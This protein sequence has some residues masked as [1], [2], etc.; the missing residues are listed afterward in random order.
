MLDGLCRFSLEA[1]AERE[2]C[3]P[4]RNTATAALTLTRIT[5]NPDDSP[6]VALKGKTDTSAF[7]FFSLN[8]QQSKK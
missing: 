5:N 6:T 1:E 7:V 2:R 8:Q 4:D 3:E